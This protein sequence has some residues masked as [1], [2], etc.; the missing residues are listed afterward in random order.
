MIRVISSP[1]SSTTGLA[2][3][4]FGIAICDL[5][6]TEGRERRERQRVQEKPPAHRRR[7][8]STGATA[9]K[10]EVCGT[11]ERR[12]GCWR[13]AGKARNIATC[14]MWGVQPG[15]VFHRV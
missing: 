1:S 2:T 5:C 9:E 13:V 10:A 6:D 7:R 14:G 3:L 11:R 8:Y 4:I 15:I 12:G